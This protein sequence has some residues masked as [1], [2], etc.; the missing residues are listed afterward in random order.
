MR[1]CVIS[2]G[3]LR[4]DK[5]AVFTPGIDDGVHIDIPVPGYLI[6][7]D[8]GENV[9][10]DTGMHPAN[11]ENPYHSFG[12]ENADEVLV[13]AQP[14]DTL[15]RADARSRASSGSEQWVQRLEIEEQEDALVLYRRDAEQWQ[16]LRRSPQ[17]YD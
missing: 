11:V 14:A 5:G 15:E 16:T 10:V 2:G 13:R 17:F 4:I 12:L 9:L 8:N 6:R 7:T 1:L 3:M